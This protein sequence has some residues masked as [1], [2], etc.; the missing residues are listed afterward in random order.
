[1]IMAAPSFSSLVIPLPPVALLIAM[2]PGPGALT[3]AELR[4]VQL[5]A[6]GWK[7]QEIRQQLHNNS[8]HTIRTHLYN[9]Y[10]KLGIRERGD[11][12]LWGIRHGITSRDG[13]QA[14]GDSLRARRLS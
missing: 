14:G 3:P 6:V 1:V 10:A 7:P 5:I 4:I 12:I 8:A 11:L 2:S 9:A 13:G